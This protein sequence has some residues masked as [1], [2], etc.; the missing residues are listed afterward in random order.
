MVAQYKYEVAE[1]LDS[2]SHYE[3]IPFLRITSSVNVGCPI[4]IGE[5]GHENDLQS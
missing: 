4:L 2:D 3:V 5:V 1:L